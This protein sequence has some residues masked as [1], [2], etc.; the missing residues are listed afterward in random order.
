MLSLPK[1]VSLAGGQ[2]GFLIG[3]SGQRWEQRWEEDSRKSLSQL[4]EKPS[5]LP[6]LF[7]KQLFL[8]GE[9]G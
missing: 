4:P 8:W 7:L 9:T 5:E 6:Q 3:E 2:G 1:A